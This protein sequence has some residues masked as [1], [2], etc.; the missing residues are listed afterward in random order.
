MDAA[1]CSVRAARWVW[2]VAMMLYSFS[3]G[4]FCKSNGVASDKKE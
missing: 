3:P 2:L 1:C 4:T